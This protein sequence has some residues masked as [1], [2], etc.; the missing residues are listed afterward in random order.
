MQLESGNVLVRV[1]NYDLIREDGRI[2]LYVAEVVAGAKQPQFI[3]SPIG[4]LEHL[5]PQRFHG[6][7]ATAEEALQA[8]IRLVEK[9]PRKEI[10]PRDEMF[11]GVKK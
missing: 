7:G 6:T 3:A 5:A 4:A 9:L 1:T 2:G 10:F 8:C 11:P